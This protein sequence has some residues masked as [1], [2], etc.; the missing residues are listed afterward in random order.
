MQPSHKSA[1]E[2]YTNIRKLAYELTLEE[3]PYQDR[4]VIG[5][6]DIN[7]IALATSNAWAFSNERRVH[8]DW[9]FG[10]KTYRRRYPNRFELAIWY[11]NT[12]CGL[13][14]GRPSYNVTKVRL[15]FIERVPGANNPLTGRVTPI[16]TTAFEVYARLVDASEV[17][18]M[19]PEASV[20]EYYSSLGYTYVQ[21]TKTNSHPDYLFKKL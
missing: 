16:S 6:T 12:L 1:E 20:I 18:I 2:K 17:R 4:A 9:T 7:N 11:G 19:F 15:D 5:I 14:L 3:L 21:G 10:V 13:A 8:W